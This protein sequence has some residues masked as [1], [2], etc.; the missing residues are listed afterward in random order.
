MSRPIVDPAL[1]GLPQSLRSIDAP[2][3]SPS[4]ASFA[5]LLL[6]GREVTLR[7]LSRDDTAGLAAAAAE[8]RDTFGYT[9]VPSG[10]S[11]ARAYID[12]AL[13]MRDAGTRCPFAV[14]LHERLVGTT[15]FWDFARFDWP[16]GAALA[17]AEGF[18]AV[19]IG[20]TWL[21]TSAQ[22]TRCNTEAKYLM[23]RHAFEAF[24]V[25]RVRLRTDAR[26]ERSRSAIERLGAKF[27]GIVR[28]DKAGSD[29]SVRDSAYFS[30][31]RDEWPSAEARL[32]AR[33]SR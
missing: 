26:N 2:D 8:G 4:Q 28:G 24:G 11:E 33:L 23:L 1:E 3:V 31:L 29:G 17:R 10:P 9:P 30:L 18:D 16:A 20:H 22:R 21:A 14:L 27:D 12:K 13:S 5:T 7:P 15:S 19:E 32:R 6:R 25:H